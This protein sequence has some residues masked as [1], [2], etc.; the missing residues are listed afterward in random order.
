[1]FVAD[2]AKTTRFGIFD[3]AVERKSGLPFLPLVVVVYSSR[4][5]FIRMIG[6]WQGGQSNVVVSQ[7]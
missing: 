1:L 6:R 7:G 2:S 5:N 3:A 4:L